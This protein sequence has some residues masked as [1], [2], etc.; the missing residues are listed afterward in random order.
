MIRVT[1][2][3]QREVQCATFFQ[4]TTFQNAVTQ[5]PCFDYCRQ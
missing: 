5:S 2:R 3:L 4:L 1:D